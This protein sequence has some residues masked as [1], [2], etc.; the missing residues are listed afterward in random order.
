[1]RA[2]IDHGID[3][4]HRREHDV[5]RPKLLSRHAG[6]AGGLSG[7]PLKALALDALR[8]FRKAG[9]GEIALIGVGGIANADDAWERIRAG[10]SLVQLYS[11]MVYEGPGIARRIALGLAARLSATR[12]RQHCRGS[13]DRVA[14]LHAF[15]SAPHARRCSCPRRLHQPHSIGPCASAR[16]WSAPP[17][18]ARPRRVSRSCARAEAPR[19]PH[20]LR[21]SRSTSSSRKAPVSAAGVTWFIR[22]AAPRPSPSTDARSRRM[23]RPL[24]WFLRD[25]QPMEF[26]DAQPGGKSVGVPGNVRMMALAHQRYGKVAWAALFQPAIKLAR[27]GFKVTPRLYNALLHY[28]ATGALSARGARDFLP[29]GRPAEAGRHIGAEIP[30]SRSSSTSLPGLGRTA[31]MSGRMRRRSRRPSA[32]HRTIQRR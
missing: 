6:E 17:T 15:A 11:A 3:G 32:A 14:A 16:E 21:C 1:M 30:H 19:T 10:A 5:S 22:I 8:H 7:R 12:L 4:N 13:R 20:S 18:R 27:G 24:T 26:S 25:G 23:Q 31:S 9:G 2:A 28:P 29:G